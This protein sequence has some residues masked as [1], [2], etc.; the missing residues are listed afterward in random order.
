MC[1]RHVGGSGARTMATSKR[2]GRRE[3]N[4]R[5]RRSQDDCLRQCVARVLGVEPRSV[6][7]FV[8]RY[9][10]RWLYYLGRWCARRH[11][12]VVHSPTRPS[13]YVVI[14][15]VGCKH[16]RI[17][18]GRSGLKHAV[19]YEA[20]GTC[21]YDGGN[22]LRSVDAVL[23]I[24]RVQRWNRKRRA[25]RGGRLTCSTRRARRATAH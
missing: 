24:V 15:G 11:L 7:H 9:R 14:A 18:T 6:P 23:V 20:D 13:R 12:L 3:A 4:R 10:G 1:V 19:V 2:A 5:R 21:S 22:P 8:R 17:G 16:I 25:G